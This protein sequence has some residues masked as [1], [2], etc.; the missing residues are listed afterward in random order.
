[1]SKEATRRY[2]KAHLK[3]TGIAW[4]IPEYER[5]VSYCE[6]IGKNYSA[7]VKDCVRACIKAGYQ[8]EERDELSV[9]PRDPDLP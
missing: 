4:Q 5:V 1:M 2:D 9:S 6:D 3:K 7:F 8:G